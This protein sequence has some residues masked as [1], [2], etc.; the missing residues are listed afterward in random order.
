MPDGASVQLTGEQGNGF[1]GVIYNGISGY[2][3]AD[4]LTI[5]GSAPAP[6]PSNPGSGS[7]STPVGTTPTGTATVTAYALNV[8]SGPSTGN[9]VVGGVASGQVVEIMGDPQGG[10][11]PIRANGLTGW[12]SGD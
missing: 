9:S 8:R 1:L 3:S 7:G 4:W 12:V 11:Y 5:G 10:F 6:A 2:A